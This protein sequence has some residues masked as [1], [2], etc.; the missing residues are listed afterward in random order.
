MQQY[1]RQPSLCHTPLSCTEL[2]F[3]VLS[4]CSR[5]TQTK[6]NTACSPSAPWQIFLPFFLHSPGQDLSCSARYSVHKPTKSMTFSS[7]PAWQ[8]TKPSLSERVALNGYK[9]DCLSCQ[10]QAITS[11]SWSAKPTKAAVPGHPRAELTAHSSKTTHKVS[12]ISTQNLRT[13]SA[14]HSSKV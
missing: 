2:G 1:K 9:W 10:R 13:L 14:S 12:E 3:L 5:W 4:T 11:S 6:P 7:P 8:R